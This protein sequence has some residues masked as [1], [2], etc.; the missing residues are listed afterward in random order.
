MTTE[1][2]NLSG[3]TPHA[4]MGHH[5]EIHFFV[6]GEPYET[7]KQVLTPNEIIREFGQKDPATNYLVQ[8]DGRQRISYQG[9]GDEPIRLHDGE[10]FQIV[11]T[12]PTPVS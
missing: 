2:G 5:H 10:R 12:G 6:D 3:D 4:G 1:T 7:D 9:K 8:I 11:F